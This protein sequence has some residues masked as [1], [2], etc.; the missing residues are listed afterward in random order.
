MN[1]KLEEIRI[2][3]ESK[4]KSAQDNYNGFFENKGRGER[5]LVEPSKIKNIYYLTFEDSKKDKKSRI[6]KILLT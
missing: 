1:I 3:S 4:K 6:S 2:E 5:S